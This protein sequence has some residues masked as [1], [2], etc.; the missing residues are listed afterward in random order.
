[1][2]KQFAELSS[3]HRQEKH[4]PKPKLGKSKI[5]AQRS[6]PELVNYEDLGP[7]TFSESMNYQPQ[8]CKLGAS[9][10]RAVLESVNN[11]PQGCNKCVALVK[12][13]DLCFAARPEPLV[14]EVGQNLAHFR[15]VRTHSTH[16]LCCVPSALWPA[17]VLSPCPGNEEGLCSHFGVVIATTLR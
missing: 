15:E 4:I 9:W 11:R 17:S 7:G 3:H 6:S 5:S 10:P 14:T 12:M 2:E 1:M 13:H 16:L 8:G